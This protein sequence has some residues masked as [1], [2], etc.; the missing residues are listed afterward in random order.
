MA[1]PASAGPATR[2]TCWTIVCRAMA[3]VM[4]SSGTSIGSAARRAGQSIPW[5]P[6]AAA[7]QTKSTHT[8]GCP[9]AALTT[10][11]ALAAAIATWV[12]TRIVRRSRA[13]ASEPPQMAPANRGTSWEAPISPT[14]SV[15]WL[16]R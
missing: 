9:R 3:L 7:E 12:K 4:S 6:A 10:S 5:K 8:R 14:I 2:A 1:T 16:S 13:S 11:P 15:E